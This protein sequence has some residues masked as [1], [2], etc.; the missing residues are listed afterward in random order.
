MVSRWRGSAIR[1]SASTAIPAGR[2]TWVGH[3]RH[4]RNKESVEHYELDRK[5]FPAD[6]PGLGTGDPRSCLS[7]IKAAV[8]DFHPMMDRIKRMVESRPAG[9]RLLPGGR[10]W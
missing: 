1:S 7:D 8:R 10:P 4:A 9:H 5:L 6:L 2:L 3:A